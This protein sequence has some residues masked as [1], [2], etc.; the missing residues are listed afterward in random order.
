[1]PIWK[2]SPIDLTDPSWEASD[3]TGAAVIRAPDEKTA[4]A[5]ASVAF[6]HATVVVPGRRTIIPP[7]KYAGLVSA[8]RLTDTRWPEEGEIEILDPADANDDIKGVNWG[9]T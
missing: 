4:R 7:W 3:H 9:D 1:M 2:L 6:A 5:A 8:E